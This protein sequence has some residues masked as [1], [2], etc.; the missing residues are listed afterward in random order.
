MKKIGIILVLLICMVY[1]ASGCSSNGDFVEIS[2]GTGMDEITNY[3][4]REMYY[5]NLNET[6]APDPCVIY[7]PEGRHT[8]ENGID[9]YGGYYYLYSTR[10]FAGTG[11]PKMHYGI[12]CARSKDLVNWEPAG[13]YYFYK[14]YMTSYAIAVPDTDDYWVNSFFWAPD[15]VYDEASETYYMYFTGGAR[16]KYTSANA[17]SVE[18]YD[19]IYCGIAVG[20]RPDQFDLLGITPVV[21]ANGETITS[22]VQ[23][24]DFEK[25]L[26][27]DY[28]FGIIDANLFIDDVDSDNDGKLD[29]YLYFVNHRSSNPFYQDAPGIWGVKMKDFITP[30]YETLSYIVSPNKISVTGGYDESKGGLWC[31]RDPA[32]G[33]AYLFDERNVNEAPYMLKHDGKYYMTYSS[34]G[35]TSKSYSVHQAIGSSPLGQFYKPQYMEGNPILISNSEHIAGTG[36]HTFAMAGDE[37]FIV[38]HKHSN[39]INYDEGGTRFL[40][41]DRASFVDI[42]FDSQFKSVIATNGPSYL[43]LQWQGETISGYKNLAKSANIS[44]SNGS[45]VEYLNDELIPVTTFLED[46][47]FESDG[48]VTLTLTWDT[49][50]AVSSVMVYNAVYEEFAFSAVDS[51]KFYFSEKPGWAS[52]E[53]T[54]GIIQ[55][56]DF[57]SRY[58][59]QNSGTIYG[60]SAAV[61]DFEP[62]NV[63]KIEISISRK[64]EEYDS[65]GGRLPNIQISELVVLGN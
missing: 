7:V 25:A 56:L 1:V 62:I 15:V 36:H 39:P 63:Y 21:N 42:D 49:P 60:S 28:V 55:N 4:N 29:M 61:A 59:D 41:V 19:N 34:N 38:Y 48:A 54:G 32:D 58:V 22:T 10:Y 44:V 50:V 47:V 46:R 31:D 33:G 2:Y 35:Y 16:P 23:P 64:F 5:A 11:T 27:L 18:E 40:A 24:I 9:N 30:D 13:V 51:I 53:Y 52:R 20:K 37:L 14:D 26:G 43:T 6:I 12:S 65:F 8:D 17:S 45:G 3:Y 57:P